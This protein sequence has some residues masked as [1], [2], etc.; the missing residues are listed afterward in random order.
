[1]EY[2]DLVF[3]FWYAWMIYGTVPTAW[4]IVGCC[5][6]ISTCFINFG[7][8]WWRY[9]D[10]QQQR[11]ALEDAEEHYMAA[12]LLDDMDDPVPSAPVMDDG[13]EEYNAL[14]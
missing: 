3:A 6:L 12:P 1:M 13:N 5:L 14:V 8:E 4:E 10:H 7:E 11:E 2:L 9:R